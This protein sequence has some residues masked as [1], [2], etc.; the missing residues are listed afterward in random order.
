MS[1]GFTKIAPAQ[2]RRV[3]AST[4]TP[5]EQAAAQSIIASWVKIGPLSLDEALAQRAKGT[6]VSD[7]HPYADRKL[8]R[9]AANRVKTLIT[10]TLNGDAVGRVATV[11]SQYVGAEGPVEGAFG[12]WLYFAPEREAKEEEAA[13]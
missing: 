2:V 10:R 8:A 12:Y 9:N 6:L 1:F 13:E 11:I 5:E 3:R 4:Y 7:A